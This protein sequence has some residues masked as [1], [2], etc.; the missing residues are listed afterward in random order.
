LTISI[1]KQSNKRY[2]LTAFSLV[3]DFAINGGAMVAA[4]IAV[5][6]D[7]SHVRSEQLCEYLALLTDLPGH[8]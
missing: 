3:R 5:H 7:L 2:G 6:E 8:T 4:D 1:A